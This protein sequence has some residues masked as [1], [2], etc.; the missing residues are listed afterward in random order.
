VAGLVL[1]GSAGIATLVALSAL[2]GAVAA[3]AFPA[4]SAITPQT[5]PAPVL[6]QAN[7]LLRLSM[8]TSAILGATT[9]GVLVAVLGPGFGLVVDAGAY[10]LA[11]LLFSRIRPARQAVPRAAGAGVLADLRDGWAEFTSRRWT[12]VVVAQF[13][14]VNA[15]FVGTAAVLGPVVADRTIG[16]AAYGFVLAAQA[17][18]LVVGGLVALRWRP[19]RPLRAGVALTALSALP[20]VALALTPTLTALLVAALLAGFAIEQFG[21]AWDV[22]LQQHVPPDR[23]AR[24]YSYDAVGS[25]VA[26]PLGQA[27]VGPVSTL[28]GTDV[29]LLGCAAAICAATPA[30]LASRSVRQLRRQP[31]RAA[32]AHEVWRFGR[33]GP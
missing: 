28:V 24:V 29:T 19:E 12:W 31:A 16:R 8:N 13:A 22:A 20:A 15:A 25:F 17:A 6:Q 21:V 32:V 7:A 9:G 2:N 1:S 11:A 4:S 14:V 26:I 23:L 33:A 3:I 30:A 18:G 27:A 5:V 10:A